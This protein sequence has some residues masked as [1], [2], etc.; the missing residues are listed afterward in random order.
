MLAPVSSL[1]AADS[2]HG[3]RA[4]TPFKRARAA[5]ISAS[6]TLEID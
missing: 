5:T 6:E 2:T 1:S 4:I 3:V